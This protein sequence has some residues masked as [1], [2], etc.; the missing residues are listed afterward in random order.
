MSHLSPDWCHQVPRFLFLWAKC[1]HRPLPTRVWRSLPG[2]CGRGAP[3]RRAHLQLRDGVPTATNSPAKL[4]LIIQLFARACAWMM[5]SS[6][7]GTKN[8]HETVCLEWKVKSFSSV[9]KNQLYLNIK[10]ENLFSGSMCWQPKG[11]PLM[12]DSP[13][14]CLPAMV[15]A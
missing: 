12:L 15:M 5:V 6:P 2:G 14:L 9:H 7:P 4:T 11:V 13:C 10:G 1:W 3:Q 8:P